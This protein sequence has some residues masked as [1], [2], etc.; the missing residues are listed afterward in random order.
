MSHLVSILLYFFVSPS[1]LTDL[2]L[3]G[4]AHTSLHTIEPR[5]VSLFLKPLNE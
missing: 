3:L 5:T 2:E 4:V 1:S